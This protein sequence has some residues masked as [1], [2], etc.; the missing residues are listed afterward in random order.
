MR[1]RQ[2]RIGVLATSSAVAFLLSQ[3]ALGQGAK[4]PSAAAKDTAR[5]LLLDCRKQVV[6]KNL[7]AALKSCQGAHAIMG[8]PSTGLELAKVFEAKGKLIEARDTAL[9]VQRF[10]NTTNNT[11]FTQAQEQATE[12]AQALNK[13]I[14]SLII[15]VAGPPKGVEIE[16]SVD[17]ENLP[18]AALSL[19][20]RVNPGGHTVLASARGFAQMSQQAEVAEGQTKTVDFTLKSVTASAN[21]AEV[22]DPWSA[23]ADTTTPSPNEKQRSVPAWA[24]IA[25]GVGVVSAGA[26]IYFGIAFG[27]AQDT[28]R[29]A[30]PNDACPPD[31]SPTTA[32]QYQSDWNRTL[33]LTVATSVLGAA[34][35]GVAIYGIV[36]T[37][38]NEP[39]AAR[40]VPLV[41]P[42]I[43]GVMAIGSF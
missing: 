20:L 28:V 39:K 19:P 42:S 34:G 35:L 6:D 33:G 30:C 16:A 11:T 23:K 15:N 4:Q 2:T 26:A 27:D 8:V 25:G 32:E 14:P 1:H 10:D 5:T 17:G 7:D 31:I 37:P 3:S 41:G 36:S 40:I 9:E 43:G 22:S 38:K 13:R 29:T 18:V 21:K 12:L 24:W